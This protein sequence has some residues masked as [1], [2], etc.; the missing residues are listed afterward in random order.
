MQVRV[1]LRQSLFTLPGAAAHVPA[2][3]CILEGACDEPRAEGIRIHATSYKDERGRTLEGQP[4]LLIIP[5]AKI[6]HVLLLG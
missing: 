6:D 2:N 5:G 3:A 1:F 4:C